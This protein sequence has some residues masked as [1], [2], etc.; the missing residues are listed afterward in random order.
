MREEEAVSEVVGTIL[1]L[2]I[3]IVL[4]TAV[5]VYVQNFPLAAPS[6]QITINAE[7]TYDPN[8]DILYENLSDQAG[9]LLLRSQTFLIIMINN[10]EHSTVLSSVN[11]VSPYG[12]STKYLEPGDE[13][14]WNSSSLNLDLSGNPTVGSLLFYK[15]SNQILWQSKNYLSNQISV[16]AIY[17]TPSPIKPNDSFTIIVQV[18]SFNPNTT[19]VNLNLSSVY[20][21]QVNETMTLYYTSGDISSFY[22]TGVSPSTLPAN[23]TAYAFV[24]CGSSSASS[25]LHLL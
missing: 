21:T 9:S 10:V 7:L 14:F 15:P 20:G 5:F 2:A 25:E 23:S 16:S 19:V 11:I 3:T 13:I 12:N 8:T 1:V 22:Y 18:Y 6:E 24:T 4:F 17:V